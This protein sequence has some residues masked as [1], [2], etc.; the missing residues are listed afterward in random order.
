MIDL[1]IEDERHLRAPRGLAAMRVQF[2]GSGDTQ[3][4]VKGQER[5]RSGRRSVHR[6]VMAVSQAFGNPNLG[7]IALEG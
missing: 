6:T 7:L 3:E 4:R 1:Y 5:G 2:P